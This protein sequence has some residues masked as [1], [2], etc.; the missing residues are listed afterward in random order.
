MI[1]RSDT[2][3]AIDAIFNARSVA[4]VGASA[5]S[6]KFGYM[7]LN[8][9]I[10]GGYNGRLYPV[11][12]K[13]DF[14]L[15]LKTYPA[16]SEIPDRIDAVVIVVP[17]KFVADVLKEAAAKG[18]KGAIIQS[19]G[20]REAGRPELESEILEVA[21]TLG[22]RIIGP[23]VQ[24]INYL[25][26]NFCPMFFPVIRLNGPLAVITQ[27]GTI[28]AALGEW[29][30]RDGLGITAMVNLGNQT[31]ICE[32]DYLDYFAQD[33]PTRAILM[34]LESVKSGPQFLRCLKSASQKKPVIVF[35]AG[36]TVAGAK[37]AASHTG[38]LA[39]SYAVFSAAC[40]QHGA[41]VAQ[42]LETLYD[43]GK[44]LATIRPPKGDRLL[45]ISTSGGAATVACDEAETSGLTMSDLP[46]A[47]LSE[48]KNVELSPLAKIQNPFDLV[49]IN[50]EHFR[51]IALLADRHNAADTILLNY[52]DPVVGGVEVAKFLHQKLNSSLAVCYMG[53]GAE[54]LQGKEAIHRAGIPVF[55]SP[56][57]A[58]RGI[59]AAVWRSKFFSKRIP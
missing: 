58:I 13:A 8:S 25:P 15:G 49:S 2:V 45:I 11:N 22:L 26:N 24:G 10:A 34:Y 17:A 41:V 53:G 4:V 23:N 46:L 31:D 35:K 50:A 9:L 36:R 47:M 20:F 32:S 38:A 55:P 5:E 51:Q 6:N 3:E 27:S 1:S 14:I 28:T 57:R 44:A 30:E 42:S 33:E 54:E 39:S 40:R 21:R 52:C 19:A 59:A 12:P 16:V 29:A 56:E 18:A 43:Q 7:T 48:L 37:S